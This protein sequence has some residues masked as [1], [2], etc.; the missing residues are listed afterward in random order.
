MTPLSSQITVTS[1][2]M[3]VQKLQPDDLQSAK[4]SFDGTMVYAQNKVGEENRVP[5]MVGHRRLVRPE[6]GRTDS[7]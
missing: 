4:G 7:W 1:G 6:L 3:L 2:G 5:M